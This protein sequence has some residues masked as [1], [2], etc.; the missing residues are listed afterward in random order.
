M[1]TLRVGLRVE[2]PERSLGFY[3]SLGYD[4]VGTVPATE[5]GGLTMLKLSGDDFVSVELVHDP[6]P[7]RSTLAASTT[8]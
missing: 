6:E 1:R 5:F 3:T 4:V 7:G 8:S 2:G